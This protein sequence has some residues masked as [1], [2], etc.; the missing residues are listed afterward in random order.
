MIRD[1]DA[2]LAGYVYVDT[3]TS[4]IGGYVDQ[5]RAAVEKDVK[6]PSGYTLQWTGQYEFQI[7]ARERL[8]VLLPIVFFIIFMLLY[9][10][11]HSYRRRWLSCCR[12]FLR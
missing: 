2:Q 10:T 8:K 9:I 12:S 11:F 5:A 7:R 1:E 3:A 6:L 4:D